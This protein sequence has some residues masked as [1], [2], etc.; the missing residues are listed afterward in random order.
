MKAEC[1]CGGVTIALIGPPVSVVACHCLACQRRSGSPFAIFAYYP[2]DDVVISGEA[3]RFDRQTD[4]GNRFESFFC[5][6]CGSTVY[7]IAG[8]HPAMIGVPV[9]AMAEPGFQAPTRS[10]WEQTRH[11][12]VTIPGDVE[13]FTRG[14][15]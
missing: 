14:R 9:G 12:W 3:T 2:A 5:S 11:S 6:R 13:H 8:K 15:N 4:E 10:V 1:Q 7:A